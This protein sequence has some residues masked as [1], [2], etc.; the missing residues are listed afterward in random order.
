MDRNKFKAT[1][2]VAIILVVVIIIM[3]LLSGCGHVESDTYDF[4][5]TLHWTA[6]GD[7]GV[8]G[9]ASSYDIRYSTEFIDADN[10]D[11]ATQL[12]GEPVPM[13]SGTLESWTFT[14]SVESEVTYY[15]AMIACDEV[16]N[17]GIISN[18]T[19]RTTPDVFPPSQI[20]DLH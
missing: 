18:N 20:T 1:L 13:V 4:E 12:E 11:D 10:W 16:S 5:V 2:Y 7:D 15:F 19:V 9:T 8:S 14:I 3:G 17:C 6:V